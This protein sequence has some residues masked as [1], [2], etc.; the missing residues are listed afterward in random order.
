MKAAHGRTTPPRLA[1]FTSFRLL[2]DPPHKGEGGLR[3]T[4][5]PYPLPVWGE[6]Q[7]I[8]GWRSSPRA[9]KGVA[10]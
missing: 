5:A 9:V 3:L 4:G 7:D 6:E 1:T 8:A 2:A 10:F